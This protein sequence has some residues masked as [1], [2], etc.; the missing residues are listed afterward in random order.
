MAHNT[1]NNTCVGS[2]C[3][4]NISSGSGNSLL[5]DSAGA[6]MTTASDN[7]GIGHGLLASEQTGTGNTGFGYDALISQNGA[8]YNT[9][10][11]FQTG[12]GITS[13]QNN[14]LIG[15]AP[16]AASYNQVTSGSNNVAIGY[17]VAVPTATAS[18]QLVISN[19]IYGTGMAGTGGTISSGSVGFGTK[20][21]SF[22]VHIVGTLGAT[23]TV[24]FS[25]LTTGTNADFLC[26][27][28]TGVVLVQTSACTISTLRYKPDWS[29]YDGT[30]MDVVR[31][32][33]VGTFHFDD[34]L[35]QQA[36][37]NARSLQIGLNAEN[38]ARVL[39]LAAVY[40][41][42]MVTPKSYRQEGVIALY[43][44]ALQETDIRIG[45]LEADNDNLRAEVEALRRSIGR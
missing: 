30:A 13:G 31:Q 29:I 36:D 2:G 45:R 9:A 28:A 38:I 4:L 23:S 12:F 25:G 21:P 5:G 24:T 43:G 40:E 6:A 11:G 39:P 35:A 3:L 41:N 20:A 42:D 27:S 22:T 32:L 26:L 7:D 15:A 16:D 34:W 10:I 8:S 37:P 17:D 14:V 44:K 1:L 19:F 18:D 33:E